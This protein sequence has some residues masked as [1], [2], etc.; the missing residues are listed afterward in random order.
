MV[1]LLLTTGMDMIRSFNVPYC[2][3]PHCK[4]PYSRKQA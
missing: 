3:V 2:N 4:V 1:K